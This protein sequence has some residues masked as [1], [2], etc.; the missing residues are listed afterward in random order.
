MDNTDGT[1][2]GR[3]VTLVEPDIVKDYDTAATGDIIGVFW[4][5]TDYAI[6][7]NLQFGMKRYFD[8]DNNEWI[9]KGLTIVDGKILDVSGCYL[10]KKKVSG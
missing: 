9:N 3:E 5:P 8:E 6:N 10:L 2:F 1:V 4:I 7:T